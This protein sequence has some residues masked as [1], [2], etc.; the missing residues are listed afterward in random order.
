MSKRFNRLEIN[1]VSAKRPRIDV[2]Q[3]DANN[4]VTVRSSF[5]ASITTSAR[6]TNPIVKVPSM[7]AF[8]DDDGDDDLLVLISSQLEQKAKVETTPALND[9]F[10]AFAVGVS[11]KTSTQMFV[12]GTKNLPEPKNEF[13]A[14]DDDDD[15][16]L[17]SQFNMEEN[18]VTLEKQ[19]EQSRMAAKKAQ[20]STSKP[21][22]EFKVP[23]KV[24]ESVILPSQ[25]TVSDEARSNLAQRRQRANELQIKCLQKHF[26]ELKQSKKKLEEKEAESQKR[27]NSQ[28]TEI[29]S[30]KFELKRLKTLLETEKQE[31]LKNSEKINKEWS[32]RLTDL[33]KQ[34]KIHEMELARKNSEIMNAS[35]KR[36]TLNGSSNHHIGSPEMP[37]ARPQIDVSDIFAICQKLCRIP[38]SPMRVNSQIFRE[39][40]ASALAKKEICIKEYEP[41]TM[42]LAKLFIADK[43]DTKIAEQ[44]ILLKIVLK[45]LYRYARRLKKTRRGEYLKVPAAERTNLVRAMQKNRPLRLCETHSGQQPTIYD[46]AENVRDEKCLVARRC[47]AVIAEMCRLEVFVRV[48][49]KADVNFLKKIMLIV[50]TFGTANDYPEYS[51]VMTA[52][53]S[54]AL[55]IYRNTR[56]LKSPETDKLLFF[57]VK[58]VIHCR[59]MSFETLH[60][61]AEVLQEVALQR[62]KTFLAHFCAKNCDMV[63]RSNLSAGILRFTKGSCALQ[64]FGA[65]LE[66]SIQYNR[67]LDASKIHTIAETAMKIQRFL[68]VAEDLQVSWMFQPPF[69]DPAPICPCI[70]K[71]ICG[72]IQLLHTCLAAFQSNPQVLDPKTMSYLTQDAVILLGRTFEQYEEYQIDIFTY[73][74]GA[75]LTVKSSFKNAVSLINQFHERFEFETIHVRSLEILNNPKILMDYEEDDEDQPME[76]SDDSEFDSFSVE[77]D[78]RN[79]Y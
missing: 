47:L 1:K 17:L 70:P 5:K 9:S 67:A 78:Y 26:E 58:A 2:Q 15:D 33:E 34:L 75:L 46:A 79:K 18:K 54:I 42:G 35:M 29:T 13:N 74:C 27:L 71:L 32:E 56:T 37:L 4:E 49:L 25:M 11:Q 14:W 65:C 39:M 7:S 66:T 23:Q 16:L 59:L 12:Q 51:A 21:A 30:L 8:P 19:K 72:F 69:G 38:R 6:T 61:V 45:Q 20:P 41:L 28:T 68:T 36:R 3:N 64:V 52:M 73:G 60:Q 77:D 57:F 31:K 22:F 62:D 55:N 48:I 10:N 24:D 44:V 63:E 76:E 43:A 50:E 40:P 53:L